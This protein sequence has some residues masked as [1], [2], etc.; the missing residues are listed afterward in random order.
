MPIHSTPDHWILETDHTGYA[1]GLDP[2]GRL[3]NF[4]WGERLTSPADYPAANAAPFSASF[5]DAGQG[6]REEYPCETGLKYVEPCFK[7]LYGDGVRDTV[8]RFD[9]EEQD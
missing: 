2:D 4:Y 5:T 8:L 1:F 7:A 6:A 9:R 3:V